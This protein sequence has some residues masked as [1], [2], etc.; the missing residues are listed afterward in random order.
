MTAEIQP[1]RHGRPYEDRV[2]EIGKRYE[3]SYPKPRAGMA[4]VPAGCAG[5]ASAVVP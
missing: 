4:G 3:A 5:T 1:G 2:S